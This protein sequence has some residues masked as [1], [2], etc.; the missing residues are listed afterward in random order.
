MKNIKNYIID[1]SK[2][3]EITEQ[4]LLAIMC[5]VKTLL[6]KNV[7]YSLELRTN[8]INPTISETDSFDFAQVLIDQKIW[9]ISVIE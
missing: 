7:N 3:I 4:N 6:A 1:E 9:D 5:A 2:S 8:H